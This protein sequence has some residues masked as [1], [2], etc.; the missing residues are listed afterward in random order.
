MLHFGDTLWSL[1]AAIPSAQECLFVYLL[2]VFVSWIVVASF[3]SCGMNNKRVKVVGSENVIV[4]SYR[5]H[6]FYHKMGAAAPKM[7]LEY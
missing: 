3:Y 2:I 4:Q 1:V 5:N 7:V 6:V